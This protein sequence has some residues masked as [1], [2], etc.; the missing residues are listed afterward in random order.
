MVHGPMSKFPS[1]EQSCEPRPLAVWTGLWPVRLGVEG[2]GRSCWDTE[3]I[4]G[5]A[6]CSSPV[7]DTCLADRLVK[8]T[9]L[10]GSSLALLEALRRLGKNRHG[11]SRHQ[12]P[13][14]PRTTGEDLAEIT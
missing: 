7:P 8:T 1:E 14:L 2:T 11:S 9:N 3:R 4:V 6:A 10:M 5:P 12:A 13:S